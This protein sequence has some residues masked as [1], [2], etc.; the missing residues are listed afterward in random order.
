M[1]RNVTD[2]FRITALHYLN[3]GREGLVHFNF[4]LNAIVSNVNNA[5]LEELN[6]VLV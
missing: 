2:I 4:L 3:A 1:K 6:L 5:T